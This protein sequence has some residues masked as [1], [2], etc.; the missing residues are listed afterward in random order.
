VIVSIGEKQLEIRKIL[1][2]QVKGKNFK[3]KTIEELASLFGQSIDQHI[4]KLYPHTHGIEFDLI[5]NHII[6]QLQKL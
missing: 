2:P 3:T 6:T 1:Y 4:Q 5:K